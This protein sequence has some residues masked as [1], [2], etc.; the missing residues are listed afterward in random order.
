MKFNTI[1]DFVLQIICSKTKT[2]IKGLKA[3]EIKNLTKNQ[4]INR[5]QGL[6]LGVRKIKENEMKI[7]W[8]KKN[9]RMKL[10]YLSIVYHKNSKLQ[11]GNRQKFD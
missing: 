1:L 8:F 5:V 10:I 2:K 4:I 3:K 7:Q 9:N 11:K 6:L